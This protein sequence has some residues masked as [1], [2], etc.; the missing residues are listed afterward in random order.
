MGAG[1]ERKSGKKGPG[2]STKAVEN[3]LWKILENC[4]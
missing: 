3:F 4:G 1:R 2:I